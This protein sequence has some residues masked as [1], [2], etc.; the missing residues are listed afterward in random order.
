[1]NVQLNF[2]IADTFVNYKTNSILYGKHMHDYH[3]WILMNIFKFMSKNYKKQGEVYDPAIKSSND[4]KDKIAGYVRKIF[5]EN[6]KISYKEFKKKIINSDS[7][8]EECLITYLL[9]S[10][11]SQEDDLML[12][13]TYTFGR[14]LPMKNITEWYDTYRLN[15]F[16]NVLNLILWKKH[17]NS[18]VYSVDYDYEPKRNNKSDTKIDS[19]VYSEFVKYFV[20]SLRKFII[21]QQLTR[22]K[23]KEGSTPHAKEN[24]TTGTLTDKEISD[25]AYEQYPFY[26]GGTHGC[27]VF[28]DVFCMPTRLTSRLEVIKMILEI[29]PS[30]SIGYIMNTDTYESGRGQHWVA[31]Y[32]MSHNSAPV[33]KLICSQGSDF[34]CFDDDTLMKKLKILGF[35]MEWNMETIQFDECNCGMFS[36]LSLL[37]LIKNRGDITKTIEDVGVNAKNIIKGA[38]IYT[39]REKT[40]GVI[41]K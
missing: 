30:L 24:F 23:F 16:G 19:R 33:C 34:T 15:A 35:G 6:P 29:Y 31:L 7:K 28:N 1:M 12:R 9:V 39:F 2:D 4:L 11:H 41:Q 21:E 32:F 36:F 26:Y 18:G 40:T 27:D 20:G 10:F 3:K 17:D 5:E 37:Y 8:S 13:T 25:L 14:V 22:D 38:D